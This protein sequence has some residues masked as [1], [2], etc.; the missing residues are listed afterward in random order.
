MSDIEKLKNLINPKKCADKN[1]YL[2]LLD[3]DKQKEWEDAHISA[4]LAMLKFLHLNKLSRQIREAEQEKKALV[5]SPDYDAEK[6][7]RVLELNALVSS[8]RQKQLSFKC[9]FDEPYFARMDLEDDKD[10]YNSYY[11]GKK[12]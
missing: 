3:G 1:F 12:G 5:N 2:D 11:T 9:F 8:A 7:R 6:Y 4:V 10:G